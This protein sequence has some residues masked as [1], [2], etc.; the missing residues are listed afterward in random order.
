MSDFNEDQDFTGAMIE[1]VKKLF[2]SR[3]AFITMAAVLSAAVIGIFAAVMLSGNKEEEFESLSALA[4]HSGYSEDKTV[5]FSK[6]GL[7]IKMRIYDICSMDEESGRAY[8]SLYYEDA[9]DKKYVFADYIIKNKTSEDVV[10]N[11]GTDSDNALDLF[12]GHLNDDKDEFEADDENDFFVSYDLYDK[13]SGN[14][15]PDTEIV[16]GAKE[17]KEFTLRYTFFPELINKCSGV[18]LCEKC[19]DEDEDTKYY[20]MGTGRPVMGKRFK[21]SEL[22]PQIALD[23]SAMEQDSKSSAESTEETAGT[24]TRS[25]YIPKKISSSDSAFSSI[26][27][28]ANPY[29]L[30]VEISAERKAADSLYADI[31]GYSATMENSA[32]QG[33]V[34]ELSCAEEGEIEKLKIMFEIKPEARKNRSGKYAAESE[35]FEGIKRFNVFYYDEEI[36]MQLPIETKFD[37][38]NNIVYAET[39]L[40]GTYALEDMEL[41]LES[42]DI[43]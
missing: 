34:F 41:L 6:N 4:Q 36:N 14:T 28:S 20:I 38:E 10:I 42:L 19:T 9:L 12:I 27:T 26:N 3:A 39:N 25:K 30:S 22:F 37:L 2:E 17:M 40:L 11:C 35:E 15:V 18:Y 8:T 13:T 7:A 43:E 5:S 32:I 16:I 29:K 33:A 1:R 24:T 21:N 31:S 23:K